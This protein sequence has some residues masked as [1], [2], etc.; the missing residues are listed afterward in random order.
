MNQKLTDK[1]ARFPEAIAGVK[2]LDE[3]TTS[4]VEIERLV[5]KS[6]YETK[7]S[8]SPLAEYEARDFIVGESNTRGLSWKLNLFRAI[9]EATF[10]KMVRVGVHGGNVRVLGQPENI[11]TT[12][13]IYN[14]LV[15]VFEGLGGTAFTEYSDGQKGEEGEAPV[16]RTGWVNQWLIAAPTKLAEAVAESR[17]HDTSQ[18]GKIANMVLEANSELTVYQSSLAPAKVERTPRAPR[19]PKAPKSPRPSKTKKAAAEDPE[20]TGFP[21]DGEILETS[22]ASEDGSENTETEADYPDVTYV[23]GSTDA[24]AATD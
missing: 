5:L 6:N 11:D 21:E 13:Q 20:T 3:L 15:P 24:D 9:A 1:L 4:L 10:C 19:D 23:E 12:L 16:N 2:T 14:A 7:Q 18:N 8:G 22:S 17:T